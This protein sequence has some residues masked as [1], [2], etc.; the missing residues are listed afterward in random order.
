MPQG[1]QA[2]NTSATSARSDPHL[3]ESLA[4]LVIGAVGIVFGDIG[5]S[6]LYAFRE[7]FNSPHGL[8]LTQANVF[9][10]LSLLFWAMTLVVSFKYAVIIMR[11]D[12]NGEG[13]TFS[14][15]ALVLKY[16][17]ASRW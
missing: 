14:L 15:L 12:N 6:P 11:A 8:Q 1:D 10:V 13:G 4:V 9:G 5:T 2:V 16:Y 17:R 7:C 3:K